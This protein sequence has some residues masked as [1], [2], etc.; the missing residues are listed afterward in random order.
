MK[1]FQKYIVFLWGILVL[2]FCCGSLSAQT[3]AE[4]FI[5]APE[6]AFPVLSLNNKK[7]LIDRYEARREKEEVDLEVENEFNGK[8]K[9]LYLSNTRMVV[10]LDKHSKIELCMLPVKGQKDP[11][12]AVIR[13]SLISPE[14]SVLSFYD[15]SWKKKDKTFHEPS[16]SFETFMKNSSS[17]AM[18]QGKLVMSQLVSITNLLTFIEGDRG[19]V[20]L[21]VHLTGI[22]G[23]PLESEESMKSLLKNEKIIFWWNNKKFL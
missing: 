6:S 13:T 14:H 22:D 19:K 17:K 12:I 15:V 1:H 20:G 2:I 9:L 5:D 18:T 21:S 11:L 4:V 10:V 7:D 3:V 16:Y 8:S 23:T